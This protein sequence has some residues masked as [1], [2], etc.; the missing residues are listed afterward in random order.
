MND[1]AP[2][3]SI[4]QTLLDT[5]SELGV[6]DPVISKTVVLISKGYFAGY[7]FPVENI[8]VVWLMAEGVVRF[9]ADDG[10]LLKT[11]EVGQGVA[12]K[13]AA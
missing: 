6:S 2:F 9:Y 4:R 13:K 1:D 8:M 5:L 10:S 12:V 7:R 3:S 11:L